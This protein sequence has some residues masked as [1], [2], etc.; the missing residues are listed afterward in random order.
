MATPNTRTESDSMGTI[1]VASDRYWGAQTERSFHNF[2]IGR[3]IFVWGRPMVKALG[4]L[5]KSAALANAEL[6][7]LP[8]DIADLIAKAGDEVNQGEAGR[9]RNKACHGQT[10]E[11]PCNVSPLASD[12][13]PQATAP[14]DCGSLTVEAAGKKVCEQIRGRKSFF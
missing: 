5:K 12:C 10:D 1:E 2:D 7:E 4:I 6:G 8:R 3:E 14:I 11:E 13:V 9:G